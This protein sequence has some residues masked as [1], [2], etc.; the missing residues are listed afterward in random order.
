LA[1]ILEQ[2]SKLRMIDPIV[3]RA[4]GILSGKRIRI[5]ISARKLRLW[6]VDIPNEENEINK[7]L[8]ILIDTPPHEINIENQLEGEELLTNKDLGEYC[9][10]HH[11]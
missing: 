6:Q 11:W 9:H 4:L 8:K 10:R 3:S 5:A 2:H 7:K 1:N